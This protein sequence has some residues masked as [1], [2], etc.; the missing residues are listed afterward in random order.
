MSVQIPPNEQFVQLLVNEAKERERRLGVGRG[1][2]VPLSVEPGRWANPIQFYRWLDTWHAMVP[3]SCRGARHKYPA[4]ADNTCITK[5][6]FDQEVRNR[7]EGMEQL[8]T[9]QRGLRGRSIWQMLRGYPQVLRQFDA[10]QRGLRTCHFPYVNRGGQVSVP[11][12]AQWRSKHPDRRP[13][14]RWF[15]FGACN[16]FGDEFHR[17][18]GVHPTEQA[19]RDILR[20]NNREAERRFVEWRRAEHQRRLYAMAARRGQLT[21]RSRGQQSLRLQ[22]QPDQDRAEGVLRARQ[23]PWAVRSLSG[24]SLQ[25]IVSARTVFLG[26]AASLSA[27][28]AVL[29]EKR[30]GELPWTGL[31]GVLLA[32]SFWSA[33]K[34]KAT[35]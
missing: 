2:V 18:D 13:L 4:Q 17:P 29:R 31:A 14:F 34:D 9:P 7:A 28:M 10:W 27:L 1:Y 19:F 24:D 33:R 5:A 30:P 20:V 25:P 16:Y 35:S 21:M 32:G 23:S 15:D 22:P 3:R 12:P 11:P 26:S 6:A 8:T